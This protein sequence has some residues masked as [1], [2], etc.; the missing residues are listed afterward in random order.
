MEGWHLIKKRITF[1]KFLKRKIYGEKKR[2]FLHYFSMTINAFNLFYYN[3]K[4]EIFLHK[5]NYFLLNIFFPPTKKEQ[6]N[7]GSGSSYF[8]IQE[9]REDK[10]VMF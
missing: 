1:H 7:K 2:G 3:E 10:E 4:Q 8:Y 9:T 5:K 6:N